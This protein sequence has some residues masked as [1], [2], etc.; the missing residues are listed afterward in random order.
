[1][2]IFNKNT[3]SWCY[4]A[5]NVRFNN[6]ILEAELRTINGSWKYNKIEIHPFLLNKPLH[7]VNGIFKYSLSKEDEDTIM[8]QLYQLYNGP[9]IPYINISKCVML[10]VD[11]PKYNI[12]REETLQILNNYKL[13]PIHVHCGYTKETSHNSK[14][15]KFL[16]DKNQRCELTLGMLEIFENFVNESMDND[17]ILYFEDDVRPINVDTNE[18]LTKLYN[19]PCDAELIRPYIGKNEQCNIANVNY[20]ISFGGGLNHAFY[21]SVYGAKKILNYTKKYNWKHCCDIDIFKIAKHCRLFPTGYDGWDLSSSNGI[22]DIT[23][24]LE[25]EEKINMYQMSHCIFNQ[26]SNPCV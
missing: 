4:S 1:M 2:S 5:K 15:N 17:W 11:V 18:N 22:N 6:N 14:F 21:I 20:N 25:E 10:S 23:E 9:T 19:I 16:V 8:K 24:K 13:P 12:I 3:N 7:N 26:T